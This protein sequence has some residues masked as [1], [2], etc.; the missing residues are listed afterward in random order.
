MTQQFRTTGTGNIC[1]PSSA[2]PVC[3]VITASSG[4]EFP[5]IK[6]IPQDGTGDLGRVYNYGC[7]AFSPEMFPRTFPPPYS[8]LLQ[9]NRALNIGIISTTKVLKEWSEH[10]ISYTYSCIIILS[11]RKTGEMSEGETSAVDRPAGRKKCPSPITTAMTGDINLLRN[12]R[13]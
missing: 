11:T 2:P 6:R 12:R 10:R 7:R 1:Y 5:L 8:L 9:E 4:R 13:I 3:S